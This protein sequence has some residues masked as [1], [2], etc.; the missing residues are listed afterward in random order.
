MDV[1]TSVSHRHAEPGAAPGLEALFGDPYQTDNPLGHV[2]ISAAGRR[3]SAAGEHL[4]GRW[5]ANAE[6]VPRDF[7]GRFDSV[8][9]LV[10]RLRPVFRRDC[11]LGIGCVDSVTAAM[12]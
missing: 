9:A 7:G 12:T 3:P 4:L 5:E 11:A 10:R 8:G 1:A 6:L 2:A